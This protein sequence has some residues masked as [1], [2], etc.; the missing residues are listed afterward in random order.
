MNIKKITLIKKVLLSQELKYVKSDCEKNDQ[1]IP[2]FSFPE[3]D[4]IILYFS[5][6]SSNPNLPKETDPKNNLD[7]N[8]QP[9]NQVLKHIFLNSNWDNEDIIE[10][11]PTYFLQILY[12]KYCLFSFAKLFIDNNPNLK[13]QFFIDLLLAFTKLKKIKNKIIQNIVNET[14]SYL[15]LE[16]L[17]SFDKKSFEII[18]PSLSD[19]LFSESYDNQ[20]FSLIPEIMHTLIHEY[21]FNF[22]SVTAKF[23]SILQMILVDKITNLKLSTQ[24]SF[25]E[26]IPQ[27]ENEPIQF[28]QSYIASTSLDKTDNTNINKKENITIKKQLNNDDNEITEEGLIVQKIFNCCQPFFLN[29]NDCALNLL[30]YLPKFLDDNKIDAFFFKFPFCFEQFIESE[31]KPFIT[32]PQKI[33]KIFQFTPIQSPPSLSQFYNNVITFPNGLPFINKTDIKSKNQ[34]S[35]VYQVKDLN[36]TNFFVS[37]KYSRYFHFNLVSINDQDDTNLGTKLLAFMSSEL[38]SKIITVL[39]IIDDNREKSSLTITI[40]NSFC[41]LIKFKKDSPYVFDYIAL[42]IHILTKLPKNDELE[43]PFP[44]AFLFDPSFEVTQELHLLRLCS[45]R[46]LLNF[47]LRTLEN[48]L[49]EVINYPL[50]MTEITLIFIE[51]GNVFSKIII[52]R[53]PRWFF[54]IFKEIGS[55]YQHEDIYGKI[56][57]ELIET[58]RI[59]LLSLL[60][61]CFQYENV[62]EII[63]KD[64]ISIHFFLSHLFEVNLQPFILDQ[65]SFYISRYD[66]SN[67]FIQ[68]LLQLFMQIAQLMPSKKGITLITGLL[69]IIIKNSPNLKS[70][71]PLNDLLCDI[72][73]KLEIKD[74]KKNKDSQSNN[75]S[76]NID[77]DDINNNNNNNIENNNNNNNTNDNNENKDRPNN[78]N[79]NLRKLNDFDDRNCFDESG[80]LLSWNFVDEIFTLLISYS[81][82]NIKILQ[83]LFDSIE[84]ILLHFSLLP[85][86]SIKFIERTGEKDQQK[87]NNEILNIKIFDKLIQLLSGTFISKYE[88][89]FHTTISNFEVLKI[90][91]TVFQA[92]SVINIFNFAFKF[93]CFSNLNCIEC[94][95]CGFDSLLLEYIQ[96]NREKFIQTGTKENTKKV[97]NGHF[98][99]PNSDSKLSMREIISMNVYTALMTVFEIMS[100]TSSPLIV[101]QV[102]SLFTPVNNHYITPLHPVL[103]EKIEDMLDNENNS[104]SI[105]TSLIQ[106]H[107]IQINMDKNFIFMCWIY[108]DSTTQAHILNVK[109][110]D[111]LSLLTIAVDKQLIYINKECTYVQIPKN[112]WTFLT[113]SLT[114][115]NNQ[116][117]DLEITI[118][119]IT[120][121]IIDDLHLD[122]ELIRLLLSNSSKNDTNNISFTVT[123]GGIGSNS[124]RMGN[125]AFFPNTDSKIMKTVYSNGP[126][127]NGCNNL[128]VIPFYFADDLTLRKLN[129]SSTNYMGEEKTFSSI[130]LNSF[131]IE[132]FLPL[133]AQLDFPFIDETENSS[134]TF[135]ATDLANLLKAAFAA[136]SI[137]RNQDFDFAILAHILIN[138]SPKHLTFELYTIFY[139]IYVQHLAAL[140]SCSDATLITDGNYKFLT[141]ITNNILVN[142][143]LWYASPAAEQEKIVDFIKEQRII[144]NLPQLLVILRMYYWYEPLLKMPTTSSMISL[145]TSGISKHFVEHGLPD[146]ERQ[147]DPNLNTKHCRRSLLSMFLPYDNL[148]ASKSVSIMRLNTESLF[149]SFSSQNLSQIE[150][151]IEYIDNINNAKSNS[152]SYLSSSTQL[153]IITEDDF[154]LIIGHCILIITSTRDPYQ[155]YDLLDFLQQARYS[156]ISQETLFI[157]HK[158]LQNELSD[159]TIICLTIGVIIAIHKQVHYTNGFNIT[160]HIE[161]AFSIISR[162]PLS[163]NSASFLESC[164][165]MLNDCP[166]LFELC[167]FLSMQRRESLLYHRIKPSPFFCTR[168][169]W[170][171]W[172]VINSMIIAP[173]NNEN[174]LEK[175]SE[176]SFILNFLIRCKPC[177]ECWF[178]IYD[179]IRLSTIVFSDFHFFDHRTRF[180][181]LLANYVLKNS[182]SLSDASIEATFIM[183]AF[184]I[185][186][187]KHKK[188]CPISNQMKKLFLKSPFNSEN[189]KNDSSLIDEKSNKINFDD[190]GSPHQILNVIRSQT[191]IRIHLDFTFGLKIDDNLHWSDINLAELALSISLRIK[192]SKFYKASFLIASFILSSSNGGKNESGYHKFIQWWYDEMGFNEKDRENNLEFFNFFY[193]KF[194]DT[195]AQI[196]EWQSLVKI[197]DWELILRQTIGLAESINKQFGSNTNNVIN[198]IN[199]LYTNNSSSNS[200]S[201]SV[202]LFPSSQDSKTTN[203][204]SLS[205]YL[206]DS[207]YADEFVLEI[208]RVIHKVVESV[209]LLLDDGMKRWELLWGNMTVIGGAWNFL[210]KSQN[211]KE[212]KSS[213]NLDTL[214]NIAKMSKIQ[215]ISDSNPKWKREFI[216]TSFYCPMKLKKNKRFNPHIEAAITREIGNYSN[217]QQL[218]RAYRGKIEDQY[219]QQRQ[220]TLLSLSDEFEQALNRSTSVSTVL[221]SKEEENKKDNHQFQNNV[222]RSLSMPKMKNGQEEERKSLNSNEFTSENDDNIIRGSIDYISPQSSP[223]SSIVSTHSLFKQQLKQQKKLKKKEMREKNILITKCEVIKAT[224][225]I[226]GVFSINEKELFILISPPSSLLLSASYVSPTTTTEKVVAKKT[227][228]IPIPRISEIFMRKRFQ[229]S[230]AIEIFCIDGKSFFINFQDKETSLKVVDNIV[231]CIKNNNN[232]NNTN[233][234][235]SLN[236]PLILKSSLYNQSGNFL[237]IVQKSFDFNEFFQQQQFT[238][239]WARGK[240]SNF[241]YLI[242]LNIFSGR[243]F[244]DLSLYP[245]FPWIISKFDCKV[246]NLNDFQIFRDLTKPIGAIGEERLNEL[247]ER[248]EEMKMANQQMKLIMRRKSKSSTN[249]SN[250]N[251]STSDLPPVGSSLMNLEDGFEDPYLYFSYVICPLAVFLYLIRMEPFTTLH[252]KMQSNKFD[253]GSRIFSSIADSFNSATA[254]LNNY[255]ELPP[256]FFFSPEVLINENRFDLGSNKHGVIDDVELPNW[257]HNN[258]AFEFVYLM[259][260]ALESD[261]VSSFL[262]DWIDLMWGYKQRGE[263]AIKAN[264]IYSSQLYDSVW[265]THS[266]AQ[267]NSN[268]KAEIEATLCHVGQIPPQI[269]NEPHIKKEVIQ[270]VPLFSTVSVV[271]FSQQSSATTSNNNRRKSK[272]SIPDELRLNET[273]LSAFISF[274]KGGIIHLSICTLFDTLKHKKSANTRRLD[275]LITD[276][277]NIKILKE[278]NFFSKSSNDNSLSCVKYFADESCFILPSGK[279]YHP[280]CG[281]SL[282]EKVSSVAFNDGYMAAVVDNDSTVLLFGPELAD[283]F[284]IDGGLQSMTNQ[285]QNNNKETDSKSS[286][287]NFV[288]K[289][290]KFYGEK[291]L[292]CE[293]SATFKVVVCGTFSGHIFICSL[294]NSVKVNVINLNINFERKKLNDND[295]NDL[296]NEKSEFFVPRKILISRS[297][298]FIICY[299]ESVS[300]SNFNE[301]NLRSNIENGNEIEQNHNNDINLHA[302]LGGD[303]IDFDFDKFDHRGENGLNRKRSIFV[304]NINGRFIRKIDIGFRMTSWCTWMSHKSFDY[305]S[306]GTDDGRIFAFEAFALDE[307]DFIDNKGDISKWN[308]NGSLV[309]LFSDHD[310][311]KIIT[312]KEKKGNI[313]G[314]TADCKLLFAPLPS[315]FV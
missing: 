313:V 113:A 82:S 285:Q 105:T 24:S 158:L 45:I 210:D 134:L 144:T 253:H 70:F 223:S 99:R 33:D 3:T 31:K 192:I 126:R 170:A 132:T 307:G 157:L 38:V 149:E 87:T 124:G 154:V 295:E 241:E 283:Q 86:E 120:V 244:T 56:E 36:K 141:C 71:T 94:H 167:S 69:S 303:D 190:F 73:D 84:R 258:D 261:F 310:R 64:T 273:V 138:L 256:D 248:M 228:R 302:S 279:L 10:S 265:D 146:S 47:E 287:L 140:N 197:I 104:P 60:E 135:K 291:V 215:N 55:V 284:T 18:F 62:A 289:P 281:V 298:G 143:E 229:H 52:K 222:K 268:K 156:F 39:K 224:K 270:K 40:L 101:Q 8:F 106:G 182:D 166:D 117:F 274:E 195:K 48:L 41:E 168:K 54:R 108:I 178:S 218:V 131:E 259:R 90:L 81:M 147:R 245:I 107:N 5:K 188:S 57:R 79:D 252:I 177:D 58:P 12:S 286:S 142:F 262:P 16:F 127:S 165:G 161:I 159:D 315:D 255:R 145:N 187:R 276:D 246:L 15:F 83:R 74:N 249:N 27:K 275:F 306:I 183:I 162:R 271:N 233:I 111:N 193:G 227:Y 9:N 267:K 179:S 180:L 121:K 174:D 72:I 35:E 43:V 212:I 102:I 115:N 164:I 260:K 221:K 234:L 230:T 93:C 250:N 20:I 282:Q 211:K 153:D 205:N 184:S 160:K 88:L 194:N 89:I 171:I 272:S 68:I 148:D 237:K 304:F 133:F 13:S 61:R 175:E 239:K 91:F 200:L 95:H 152:T 125:F 219:R 51:L 65:F 206:F 103:V 243:S 139:S 309:C 231:K 226:L 254:S 278:L 176:S 42:F 199:Y 11:S 169:T 78:N 150:S 269:F 53:S 66:I 155:A 22:D 189:A 181:T 96:S 288:G 4:G 208:D 247:L 198:N 59:V 112:R 6:F 290:I 299:A 2:F 301:V 308:K 292:C 1:I 32:I 204:S 97:P 23:S 185:L 136:S 49:R 77:I 201:S 37:D 116:R 263:E 280:F 67:E 305:V 225:D 293:I 311:S 114:N 242:K 110:N 202:T 220:K 44:T 119:T 232:N 238:S 216:T 207:S 7:F 163:S 236:I 25:A 297:W 294:F 17:H 209:I 46:A 14:F 19:F 217:A 277:R 312:C 30:C 122:D 191:V 196:P 128:S 264:N 235:E 26:Q 173:K 186:F 34:K 85:S 266:A 109:C 98:I 214:D 29:L 300:R 172:A 296:K 50:I 118:E 129:L 130:L 75:E 80:L 21:G 213:E 63:M 151:S 76:N 314:V 137:Q 251:S 257:V 100:I 123:I 92:S 28:T 203:N 240:M